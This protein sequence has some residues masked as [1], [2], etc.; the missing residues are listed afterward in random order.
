MAFTPGFD[1]DLFVSYAHLDNDPMGVEVEGWVRPSD[2]WVDALVKKVQSELSKRLGSG[3]VRAYMDPQ[4]DGN[5]PIT[6]ELLSA[7]R[8]SAMLMVILS[9]GYLHS[10]WCKR[11]RHAFLAGIQSRVESGSVFVVHAR[12]ST[13]PPSS[14][15]CS[16]TRSGYATRTRARIGRSAFRTRSSRS[17][18]TRSSASVTASASSFGARAIRAPLLTARGAR[19]R[20]RRRG[21]RCSSPDRPRTSKNAKTS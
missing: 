3:Q 7:V 8:R 16:V 1:H 4:L 13:F 5:R 19:A 18:S 20:V 6:P 2:G 9:P 14:A 21:R 12:E 10:E 11:E 15:I 17:S